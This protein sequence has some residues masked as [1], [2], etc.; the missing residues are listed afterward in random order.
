V[1]EP[2]SDPAPNAAAGSGGT[3]SVQELFE[4]SPDDETDDIDALLEGAAEDGSFGFSGDDS[5]DDGR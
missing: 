4:G 2:T 1:P 5:S 3:G